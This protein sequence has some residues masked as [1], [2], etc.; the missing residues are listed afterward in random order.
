MCEREREGKKMMRERVTIRPKRLRESETGR[1]I[2][3]SYQ[4]IDT[5]EKGLRERKRV[6]EREHAEMCI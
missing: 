5:I 1:E 2:A 6:G 3:V 4:S